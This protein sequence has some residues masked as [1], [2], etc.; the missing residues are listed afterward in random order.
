[1]YLNKELLENAPEVWEETAIVERSEQLAQAIV[2][3]WPHAD[4]I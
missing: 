2:E 4:D 3:I 1:M